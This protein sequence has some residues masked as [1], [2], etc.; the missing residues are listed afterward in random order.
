MKS[1]KGRRRI[2]I[3]RVLSHFGS[4]CYVMN[5]REQLSKFKEKADEGIFVGYS[6]TPHTIFEGLTESTIRKLE[7][8]LNQ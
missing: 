6:T 7:R 2:Y 5:D 3:Y 1:G 8:S 4:I